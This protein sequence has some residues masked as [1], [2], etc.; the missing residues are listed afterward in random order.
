[1]EDIS[2]N[3]S[4]REWSINILNITKIY[5]IDIDCLKIIINVLLKLDFTERRN[6]RPLY[7]F[8]RRTNESEVDCTVS[9]WSELA[10]Y[11]HPVIPGVLM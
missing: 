7:I 6:S 2:Y 10:D 9:T 5:K 4:K 8:P 11:L 1:M 3:I